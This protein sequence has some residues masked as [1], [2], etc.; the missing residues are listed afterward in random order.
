[1]RNV[2]ATRTLAITWLVVAIGLSMVIGPE[3]GLR[4][5]MWLGAHNLLCAVGAGHELL[6]RRP[7][8]STLPETGSPPAA[9][10]PDGAASPA[11]SAS[12]PESPA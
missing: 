11:A 5:W 4:G 1:M 9:A 7:A 6:K 2:S 3:L 8:T 10:S 12:L